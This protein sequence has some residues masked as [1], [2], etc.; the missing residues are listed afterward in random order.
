MFEYILIKMRI[1]FANTHHM[2]DI[3]RRRFPFP[4]QLRPFRHHHN[5][6]NLDNVHLLR[7]E[8]NM[9]LFL[10]MLLDVFVNIISNT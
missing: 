8:N 3:Q 5:P 7:Y 4:F 9:F 2:V 1:V 6:Y 10:H